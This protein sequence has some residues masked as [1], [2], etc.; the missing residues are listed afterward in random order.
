MVSLYWIVDIFEVLCKLNHILNN[1]D[2]S[3][4]HTQ[5]NFLV[6]CEIE[7]AFRDHTTTVS[8]LRHQDPGPI[9]N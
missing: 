6:C 7:G 8:L 2:Y 4:Q 9:D 1:I 5:Y 3:L